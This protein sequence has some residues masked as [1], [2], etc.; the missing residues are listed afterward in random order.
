MKEIWKDVIW[1][2]WLYKISNLWNVIRLY[3]CW[4][5]KT[6]KY[7]DTNWYASVSFNKNSIGKRFLVHR[8]VAQVFIPNLK[9]KTQINH[10]NGIKNDNR[11]K[12]LER[13]TRSEN[14]KH[15]YRTLKR[16]PVMLW[17]K[18]KLHHNSK[19]VNQYNLDWKF[20]KTWC[21]IRDIQREL[22]IDGAGISKC[23]K[24]KQKTSWWFIWKFNI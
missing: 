12:N 1:Y 5:Q 19:K 7:Q 16:K 11:V 4:K 24:W 13:C 2:E 8:L 17:K 6:M 21:A 23:C 15:C 9:N 10:I 18:W 14:M 3:K 20:V 22:W